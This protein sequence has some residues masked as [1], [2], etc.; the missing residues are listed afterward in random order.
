M[1]D[2]R[3]T[4]L[5]GATDRI[6]E[7][8]KWLTISLAAIGGVL[9]AGL[10]LT[11]VGQLKTGSGRFW[12]AILGGTLALAGAVVILL[13]TSRVMTGESISL[14]SIADTDQAPAGTDRVLADPTLL[15]G[16]KDVK[17]LRAEYVSAVQGRNEAFRA[18]RQKPSDPQLQEAA[19]VADSRAVTVSDTVQEL[20]KVA[21][22]QHLA[23]QWRNAARSIVVG[24]VIAVLGLAVYAWSA[25]PPKEAVA[26]AAAPNVV[27]APT[28][29]I[30]TLTS[31]GRENL[32]N[33]LG[34]ACNLTKP[35]SVLVLADTDAGPDV[36]TDQS[37]DCARTRF[38]LGSGWGT[39]SG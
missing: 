31:E 4:G 16:Y 12:L 29:K 18:Y 24:G 34:Q 19:K 36:L 26:S 38:I 20:M 1:T 2:E 14:N 30:M 37:P 25:N 9:V 8:A 6:R 22:Y 23:Y 32:R 33:A 10:Q 5:A 3:S 39:V 11:D 13:A 17:A 35:I 15:N 7:T 27:T 21:S 28:A